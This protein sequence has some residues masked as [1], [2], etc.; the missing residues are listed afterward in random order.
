MVRYQPPSV[1]L[2]FQSVAASAGKNVVGVIL[3]GKGAERAKGLLAMKRNGAYTLA[4]NEVCC[5]K[6]PSDLIVCGRRCFANRK[7]L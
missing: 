4:Q 2:L 6:R 5:K 1:D 7:K 3:T